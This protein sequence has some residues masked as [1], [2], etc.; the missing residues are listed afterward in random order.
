[1]AKGTLIGLMRRAVVA[2]VA[3]GTTP[4]ACADEAEQR[5]DFK[6]FALGGKLDAFKATFKV[7]CGADRTGRFDTTCVYASPADATYAGEKT[8]SMI[9]GFF[10]DRLDTAEVVMPASSYDRVK[11]VLDRRFGDA[12]PR[13]PAGVCTYPMNGD[14]V[15]L[16]FE[17]S[18]GM[19]L[20]LYEAAEGAGERA[21]RA[22]AARAR[23]RKDT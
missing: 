21:S 1:M 6:G 16:M 19:T 10:G 9:F 3:V 7:K 17:S 20:V 13:G 14:R 5:M 18:T 4:V 23:G 11:R 8:R 22:D 2:L 12:T 15:Y